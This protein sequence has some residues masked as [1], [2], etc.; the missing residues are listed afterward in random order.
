VKAREVGLHT[1]IVK[2]LIAP[3][4]PCFA[5]VVPATNSVVPSGLLLCPVKYLQFRWKVFIRSIFT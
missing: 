2:I 1:A 5:P 3:I 4:N